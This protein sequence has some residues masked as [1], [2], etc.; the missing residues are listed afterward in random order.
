MLCPSCGKQ[1]GGKFGE[2]CPACKAWIR[3]RRLPDDPPAKPEEGKDIILSFVA[4]GT[5]RLRK[6]RKFFDSLHWR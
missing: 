3:T 6:A 2:L 5:N 1:N 4:Y